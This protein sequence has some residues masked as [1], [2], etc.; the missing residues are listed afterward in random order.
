VLIIA[1]DIIRHRIHLLQCA[2][3]SSIAKGFSLV[4]SELVEDDKTKPN[5]DKNAKY[6]IASNIRTG[7]DNDVGFGQLEAQTAVDHS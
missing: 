3:F 5:C 2:L 4:Q 7:R 1:I 6:Y